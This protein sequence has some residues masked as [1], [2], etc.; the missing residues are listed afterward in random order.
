MFPNNLVSARA[1]LLKTI[2]E[3]EAEAR[4]NGDY[5]FVT[6]VR[7]DEEAVA[8]RAAAALVSREEKIATMNGLQRIIKDCRD[9][10]RSEYSLSPQEIEM[11]RLARHEV[12]GNIELAELEEESGLLEP[13]WGSELCSLMAHNIITGKYEVQSS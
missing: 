8:L 4:K 11:Q 3:E 2:H 7:A 13:Y 6:F 10:F 9:L 12:V 1:N 5:R